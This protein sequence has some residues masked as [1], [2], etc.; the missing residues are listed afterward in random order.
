[1]HHAAKEAVG[2]TQYREHRPARRLPLDQARPHEPFGD[3]PDLARER[4]HHD[5]RIESRNGFDGENLQI[6]FALGRPDQRLRRGFGRT[7]EPPS[8]GTISFCLSGKWL[9][10]RPSHHDPRLDAIHVG[11]VEFEIG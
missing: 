8:V 4:N 6:D 1:M 10:L 9:I 7:S 3:T 11:R 5:D 2:R